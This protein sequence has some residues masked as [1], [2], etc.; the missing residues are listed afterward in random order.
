MTIK[1]KNEQK[2]EQNNVTPTNS[3]EQLHTRLGQIAEECKVIQN[4]ADNEQRALTDEEVA[5]LEN[6]KR[7]FDGIEKEIR[8]RAAANEMNDRMAALATPSR[9]IS[10]PED[11]SVDPTNA[12]EERA[13]ITGGLPVGSSKS[14][15]GFRSMGEFALAARRTKF[16]KADMR[17]VNAPTTFGSEGVNEDGGFAVPPDFRQNIMKQILGEESLMSM[18]DMQTTNSNSLSLPLDTTTPWQ[19]SGGVVPQW[20]GEG[21]N[22]TPTKPRLGALETKLNKLAALVPITEELLQ[23]AGA[24]TSWLSSKVPEKFNSFINDVI[25]T[26][27][28]VGKPLGMLNS[29]AKVTVAAVSG[30][31]ANTVVARNIVDMYARSYGPL[32]RNGVWL[33]NQDVEPLL[34]TL[35]MPGASPSFPAYLPPGGLSAAPYATLLGRPVMPIEA[36]PALGTEGDIM[37]VIPNQYLVVTKG[38]GMRTDVSIH[39]YFDSDHTAFRFVMRI[40]GQSYWPAPAARRNGSNTLSPIVT[41]SSTRT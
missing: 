8:T 27:D 31:G 35:V 37:F 4:I 23:D 9:R 10:Q 36:C 11:P 13:R 21:A 38:G 2:S 25:I 33:I 1:K 29:A 22:L 18:C 5:N 34:Q 16:G 30:Q 40:G 19:T 6:F 24:L 20:L 39:L 15:F 7:E 17:I 28:G 12:S 32:R 26:G 3:I 14:T 41:L